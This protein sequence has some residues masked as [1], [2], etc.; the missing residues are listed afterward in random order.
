MADAVDWSEWL[1]SP[2]LSSD[3]TAIE[4]PIAF[5]DNVRTKP[6]SGTA[7]E[8]YSAIPEIQN[9]GSRDDRSSFNNGPNDGSFDVSRSSFMLENSQNN[10]NR[11]FSDVD[12]LPG[13]FME[14]ANSEFDAVFD[15]NDPSPHTQ[16]N[17]QRYKYEFISSSQCQ[18][19]ETLAEAG[20][21]HDPT[22]QLVSF[23]P[24]TNT[25][26]SSPQLTLPD[27]NTSRDVVVSAA[28]YPPLL[29]KLPTVFTHPLDENQIPVSRYAGDST[30]FD[31]ENS[32][33]P[34]TKRPDPFALST[35]CRKRK[36]GQDE[37]PDH[38]D[39]NRKRT[40]SSHGVPAA[41]CHSFSSQSNPVFKGKNHGRGRRSCL[42]CNE[43]KL[44]VLLLS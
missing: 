38:S 15:Y 8:D 29:P 34:H 19:P 21:E 6:S 40:K 17:I 37:G 39:T 12:I 28:K 41:Y 23:A 36:S 9:P 5:Q 31:Q 27:T 16:L 18:A 14:S 30:T 25:S 42:R 10:A 11:T 7:L 20:R 4:Y 26:L 44:K 13:D 3:D 24:Q 43:Q 32:S 33:R 35:L 1:H 22:M 2:F